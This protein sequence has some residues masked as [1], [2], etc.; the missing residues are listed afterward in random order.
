MV[1]L[2]IKDFYVR[3]AEAFKEV[4]QEEQGVALFSVLAGCVVSIANHGLTTGLLE[5]LCYLF[6]PTICFITSMYGNRLPKPMFLVPLETQQKRDYL[7]TAFWLKVSGLFALQFAI[8]CIEAMCGIM[9]WWQ[10]VLWLYA[11]TLWT[12]MR[13][14]TVNRERIRTGEK[15]SGNGTKEMFGNICSLFNCAIPLFMGDGRQETWEI[16]MILVMF[17]IQSVLCFYIII[18]E[19]HPMMELAV[20]YEEFYCRNLQEGG[21][22]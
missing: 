1:K 5:S 20:D 17:S 19:F 6:L 2:V 12:A 15:V 4:V 11:G 14:V 8:S 22:P 16:A 3:R 21:K 18:K 13:G 7:Y 10:A 9:T